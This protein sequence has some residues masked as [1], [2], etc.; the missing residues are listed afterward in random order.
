MEPSAQDRGDARARRQRDAS[1]G[2]LLRQQGAR[3]E[4]PDA[5]A[6]D[7][8]DMVDMFAEGPS[9]IEWN[10]PTRSGKPEPTRYGDWERKGRTF[11]F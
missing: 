7:D 2:A 10:G 5:D 9:G 8:E 11:D 3:R 4:G 6:D 1:R